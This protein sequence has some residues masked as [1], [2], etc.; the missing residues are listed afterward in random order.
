MKPVLRQHRLASQRGAAVFVVMLVALLLSALGMFAIRSASL[1]TLASGYNRQMSQTHYMTEYGVL[2]MASELTSQ[3]AQNYVDEAWSGKHDGECDSVA[4]VTNSTCF[5][6]Y[7]GDLEMRVKGYNVQNDML[8]PKSGVFPGSLGPADL[9]GDLVIELTDVHEV[10]QPVEGMDLAQPGGP[11]Y[12]SV[13]ISA[14]GHVRPTAANPNICAD[15]ASRAVAGIQ[16]S[17]AHMIIGPLTH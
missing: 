2:A 9:E 4:G 6:V 12:Y 14:T 7:Y 15:V 8:I 3:G 16:M 11:K 10:G 17:R 5:V 13:T 1:A